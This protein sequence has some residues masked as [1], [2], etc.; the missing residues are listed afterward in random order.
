MYL[1]F[2]KKYVEPILSGEKTSTIRPKKPRVAVGDIV[3]FHVG[4]KPAFASAEILSVK[5]VLFS[6]LPEVRQQ[7]VR[8][9]YGSEPSLFG[10]CKDPETVWRVQFQVV[11]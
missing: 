7:G 10:E 2:K 5:E 1:W 6:S 8:A 3:T 4:P 9:I 11:T